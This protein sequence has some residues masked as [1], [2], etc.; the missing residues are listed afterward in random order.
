M[1]YEK[2]VD[3]KVVSLE[4]EITR[5]TSFGIAEVVHEHA[6]EA[7]AFVEK[8]DDFTFT[9]EQDKAVLRKIDLRIMPLVGNTDYESKG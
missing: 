4:P 8:H 2:K 3:E 9:A 5:S 6:D 1:A 7:L